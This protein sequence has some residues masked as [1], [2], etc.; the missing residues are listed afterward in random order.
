MSKMTR[1]HFCLIAETIKGMEFDTD[2]DLVNGDGTTRY[3][4]TKAYVA[5]VFVDALKR[6]NG[7]FNEDRFIRACG[8]VWR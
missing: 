8:L 1:Q 4:S 2:P 7:R 5:E 6:T 3:G